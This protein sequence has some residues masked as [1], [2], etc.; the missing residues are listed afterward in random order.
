M[1]I[2][3]QNVRRKCVSIALALSLLFEDYAINIC[4]VYSLSSLIYTFRSIPIN[5]ICSNVFVRLDFMVFFKTDFIL[6]ILFKCL[7]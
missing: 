6:S 5:L 7:F 1:S 3:S 2:N 4:M